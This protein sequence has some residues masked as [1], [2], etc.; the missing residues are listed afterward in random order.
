M[1]FNKFYQ[2][3]KVKT[4][5]DHA[6]GFLSNTDAMIF[7]LR[8]NIGGSP[9]LVRYMLSH[10]FNKQTLLWRIHDRGNKNIYDHIS[11]K[12]VGSLRLKSDYPLYILVG[13]NT[14]SAAEIFSYTL[15]HFGMA[16]LIGEKTMGIAHAV[17]AAK[18]NQYF[19]GRFSV[20]RP[21]NP[22]TK[23]SWE[24]IGVIPDIKSE[25]DKSLKVAHTQA[26]DFLRKR[27]EDL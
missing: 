7:D 8:D 19:T 1:K 20:A 27:N 13:P 2:D 25:S 26:L 6:F 17:N 12:G 9:E 22:I 14:A 4:T 10:F 18:I 23:T 11:I 24:V 5:V 21:S 15:K 16:T 3:E